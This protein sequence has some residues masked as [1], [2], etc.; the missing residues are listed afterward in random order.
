MILERLLIP[1]IQN[2]LVKKEQIIPQE[3]EKEKNLILKKERRNSKKEVDLNFLNL[4]NIVE[5]GVN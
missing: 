2:I 4:K 1:I 5:I 3:M